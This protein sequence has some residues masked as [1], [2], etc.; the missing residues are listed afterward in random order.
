MLRLLGPLARRSSATGCS[1]SRAASSS[2]NGSSSSSGSAPDK[3]AILKLIKDHSQKQHPGGDVPR[4]GWQVKAATWV[5][6]MH[7]DR[8]DVKIGLH[9]TTGTFHIINSLKP[10]YV[11]PDISDFKLKPYVMHFEEKAAGLAAAASP[12]VAAEQRPDS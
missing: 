4:K 10:Q 2:S 8:G 11:V 7:V 5:K 9:S 6:K 3:Q 1:C 12:S